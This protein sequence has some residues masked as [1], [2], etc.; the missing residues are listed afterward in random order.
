M[1]LN[2]K[3]IDLFKTL[4]KS[5]V[6]K[7]LADFL[8][9]LITNMCDARTWGPTDTKEVSVKAADLVKSEIIDRIRLQN[10]KKV[11]EQFNECE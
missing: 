7:D 2:S 10:N 5:Q 6:G 11:K 4:N 8:D 1:I 9:R 3:D